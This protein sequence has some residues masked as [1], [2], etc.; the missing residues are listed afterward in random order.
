MTLQMSFFAH[1]NALAVLG[2]YIEECGGEEALTYDED[3][4]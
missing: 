2:L 1:V 3:A 4:R